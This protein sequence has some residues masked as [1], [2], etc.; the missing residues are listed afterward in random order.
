MKA[1][2]KTIGPSLYLQCFSSCSVSTELPPHRAPLSTTCCTY[3][4]CSALQSTHKYSLGGITY[5]GYWEVRYKRM[6]LV[7]R[8]TQKCQSCCSACFKQQARQKE[9]IPHVVTQKARRVWR[10]T[11]TCHCASVPHRRGSDL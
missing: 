1:T 3:V 2:H 11:L 7:G 10:G 8:Q 9:I 4:P 6:L 5:S